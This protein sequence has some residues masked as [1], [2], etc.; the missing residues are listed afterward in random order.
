MRKKIAAAVCVFLC[1]L[2]STPARANYVGMSDFDW[3]T[4]WEDHENDT[5]VTCAHIAFANALSYWDQKFPDLIPDDLGAPESQ[6]FTDTNNNT[7]VLHSFW[8]L[9]T[10]L[11]ANQYLGSGDVDTAKIADGIKKWFADKKVGLS[12]HSTSGMAFTEKWDF[13]KK[14]V[15][16][17][18]VPLVLL[19]MKS[20]NHWVTGTG[21]LDN[22]LSI[23]DPN[24]IG[25]G[26]QAFNVTKKENGWYITYEGEEARIWSVQAVTAT[27]E[28]STIALLGTGIALL[29]GKRGRKSHRI[30]G[31][32]RKSTTI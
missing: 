28:P 24:V 29:V 30:S 31:A 21:Y 10:A 19:E 12:Y 7:Y 6:N 26:A 4:Y 25:A 15:D 32:S 22:T 9:M 11:T 5:S 17:G 27:P 8:N 18:E 13:Y 1:S 3:P 20:G 16:K 14:M 23:Y 2:A